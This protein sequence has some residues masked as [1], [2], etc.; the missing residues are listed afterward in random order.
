MSTPKNKYSRDG[1]EIG[2][3]KIGIVVLGK[4][5]FGMTREGLRQRFVDIRENPDVIQMDTTRFQ[6]A[7]DR[8]N[9]LE[10]GLLQWVADKLDKMAEERDE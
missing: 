5:D 7:A 8:G 3:S 9:Y 2:A 4:N 6:D 10:D 1:F